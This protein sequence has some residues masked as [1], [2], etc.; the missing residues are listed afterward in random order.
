MILHTIGNTERGQLISCGN[1]CAHAWHE[2]DVSESQSYL[3]STRY[4]TDHIAYV[5]K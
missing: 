1:V 5:P 4:V 3:I 2:L